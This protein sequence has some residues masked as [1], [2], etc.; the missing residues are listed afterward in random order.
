M[1]KL[2]YIVIIITG[3]FSLSSC[4][5]LDREPRD[6][7]TDAQYW[8]SESKAMLV[9]NMAYNQMYG[10]GIM[11]RDEYL[12]DNM[13]HTYGGSNEST[14]RR[15]QAT[16]SLDLFKNEWKDSYGGIKTCHVFLKNIDRVPNISEIN[17]NRMI[18]EIR[19][20]R[21]FIFFRMTNYYGDIPFFTEEL[22][23]EESYVISRTSKTK[24]M[25][26]IHSELDDI[27]KR[28]YLPKSDNLPKSENGR[29]TIAA[30]CAFQARAYLYE[31]NYDK[32]K[33]FAGRIIKEQDKYGSYTSVF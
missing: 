17:K 7:F 26:F 21:A 6:K 8:T 14:I 15:G 1:K 28:G 29:I 13:V 4:E 24:V 30:A 23:L 3:L 27:I 5:D 2:L 22:S 10:A 20:I 19:F 9:V 12:S 18:D 11:W 16:S 32:V 25:E 33:D 31:N